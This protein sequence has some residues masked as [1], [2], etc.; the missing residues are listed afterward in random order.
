MSK[1]KMTKSEILTRIS[2]GRT[3][4]VFELL[5]LPDWQSLISQGQ[6]TL[7][8]WF[9]YYNDV[10][11]MKA[12]IKAGGDLSSTDVNQELCNAAFFG[13]WK[14]VDFLLTQ[15]ASAKAKVI[16]TD[17][18]AL[19]NA[20]AKAGRPYF[21]YV[22]KLLV[23]NGA[24]LNARTIPDKETGA[25]MRDVRT[26]GETPLHRAAA[27]ADKDTIKYLLDKG[28]DKEAKDALGNSPLSWASE[29]LRPAEILSLL[30][31]GEHRIGQN[32]HKRITSDHGAGWGNGM[33][34]NL[35]GEF[36]TDSLNK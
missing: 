6:V 26:K 4:L 16:E 22:V 25:F 30:S 34:W 3:D 19:H 13:H 5:E 31:F 7:L 21:I 35:I 18:T 8:Q 36:V 32:S 23:E 14:M 17:E 15:G 28:A 29:H 20:L 24:D 11:A 9:V 12:I 27:Y 2:Q 10:T 33:D 1:P